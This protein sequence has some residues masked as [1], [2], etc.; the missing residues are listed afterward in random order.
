MTRTG[1]VAHDWPANGG[2]L[3]PLLSVLLISVSLAAA[4][5]VAIIRH[6]PASDGGPSQS[7]AVAA[8][9][10][11]PS[12]GPTRYTFGPNSYCSMMLPPWCGTE[13]AS[14]PDRPGGDPQHSSVPLH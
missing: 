9:N 10:D 3:L 14:A 4:M 13:F 8:G 6:W 2:R 12:P 1:A 11:A 5:N 7:A